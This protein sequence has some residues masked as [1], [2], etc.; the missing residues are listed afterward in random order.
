MSARDVNASNSD[1]VFQSLCKH[2]ESDSEIHSDEQTNKLAKNAIGDGA[3]ADAQP[4]ETTRAFLRSIVR[5]WVDM[6]PFD[7]EQPYNR[8]HS[9]NGSGSGAVIGSDSDYLY[10]LT[11]F[12]VIE[13]ASRVHCSFATLGRAIHDAVMLG[14]CP[15]VDV[16]LLRVSKSLLP[17]KG[18]DSVSVLQLGN[19]DRVQ[20]GDEIRA[21]GFPLGENSVWS[22][23]GVVAGRLAETGQFQTDVAINHGN[24]GGPVIDKNDRLIGVVV[25]K[26]SRGSQMGY[27]VPLAQF[28]HRLPRMRA[29]RVKRDLGAGNAL[30]R[31]PSLNAALG[32]STRPLLESLD[33]P[34]SLDGAFV[35]YILP[36]SALERAGVRSGDVLQMIGCPLDNYAQV[37]TEFW[38]DRL[39]INALLRRA[40]LPIELPVRW[41]SSAQKETRKALVLFDKP[42]E[43]GLAERY[44]PREPIDYETFGGVVVMHLNIAHMRGNAK[45]RERYMY[46]AEDPKL[47]AKPPLVVTHVMPGS[48]LSGKA[49]LEPLDCITRVNNE[50]VH[51]LDEYR[52]ALVQGAQTSAFV[53]WC[54]KDNQKTA[55]E[56]SAALQE[57]QVFSR[58]IGFGESKTTKAIRRTLEKKIRR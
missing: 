19:S 51:T 21:V 26:H 55:L 29:L 10:I 13:N 48:S 38:N 17:Q 40:P 44:P 6:I 20:S 25:S 3:H 35:R 36:G 54:T 46:V 53:T 7:W 27:V 14:A 39:H 16:A 1:A 12:H 5:I 8:Q 47:F 32:T 31:I 30:V 2:R 58:E 18:V 33:A 37:A 11:A 34:E 23:N 24:S 52:R 15:D 41:W 22:T 9:A 45:F 50:T 56:Y 28:E 42:I 43:L 57:T 4:E 49:L